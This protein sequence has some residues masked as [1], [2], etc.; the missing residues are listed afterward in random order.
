MGISERKEREKL[1]RRADIL[2]AAESVF[3]SKGFEKST[4]DDIADEAELSKGT[5]YL[6]FKSKEDLHL[7]VAVGAIGLMDDLTKEI[8]NMKYTAMEKLVKLGWAFI[9]FSKE[10]P[11]HM[12]S[13]LKLEGIDLEKTSFSLDDLKKVIYTRSPVRLV[14]EFIEQG[15]E[16]KSIRSDIPP[17]LIAHTLWMQLLGVIQIV[18]LKKGLFEMLEL[19]PEALYKNHIELVLNG[20]KS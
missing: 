6:Y 15:I 2:E 8:G 20:I 11:D 13:I 4:M 3:F 19:T 16:E 1:K 9:S 17:L 14:M 12:G 18:A 7:A 5:L 10:Y